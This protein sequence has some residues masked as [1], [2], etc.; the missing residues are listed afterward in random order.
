MKNIK[1]I[2]VVILL[3]VVSPVVAQTLEEAK[4]MYLKGEYAKTKEV[5]RKQL[6]SRPNDAQ[7]NQWYGVCL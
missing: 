6:K 7:L 5:F 4:K 2:I 1:N 3:F